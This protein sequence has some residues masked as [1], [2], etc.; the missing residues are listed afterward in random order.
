MGKFAAMV[1][2][3]AF[4]QR[5]W[6]EASRQ[7][8]CGTGD[9]HSAV[10]R[11]NTFGASYLRDLG[12]EDQTRRFD[13]TMEMLAAVPLGPGARVLD[14]GA[15]PGNYAVP[16]AHRSA[17][18]V[19]VEAAHTMTGLLQAR[20]RREGCRNVRVV[21][22]PWQEVDLDREGFRGGFDLVFAALTP[23][24]AGPRDFLR[25]M[26]ASRGWCC[27][28]AYAGGSGSRAVTELWPRIFPDQ[29]PPAPPSAV[30][31]AFNLLC[32]LGY[33]PQ[34]RFLEV[35]RVKER[36][37]QE[38]VRRLE[39]VFSRY[40]SVEGRAARLIREYVRERSRGGV[41]RQTVTARV[42][43]LL[44]QVVPEEE[45]RPWPLEAAR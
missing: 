20:V 11:W 40:L 26:E 2:D 30:A 39:L 23:A 36:P 24:V 32:C 7:G 44:W 4:W 42:G 9:E 43:I 37:V 18:V 33:A 6:D 12:E 10:E 5:I 28:A 22:A 29:A 27:Y 3:S 14:I 35:R 25:M 34:V 13:L 21:T 19:A 16:L 45:S 8:C 41:F 17:E 31:F 1:Q 38:A 15:G